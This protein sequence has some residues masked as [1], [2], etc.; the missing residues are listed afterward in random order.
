ML[1][2]M[3]LIK[4]REVVA[5]VI[6]LFIAAVSGISS[7]GTQTRSRG[8]NAIGGDFLCFKSAGRRSGISVYGPAK[9]GIPFATRSTLQVNVVGPSGLDARLLSALAS[10]I[11]ESMV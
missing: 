5:G 6:I 4:A 7:N 9:T 8:D 11:T 2:S 10:Q 3:S 1:L